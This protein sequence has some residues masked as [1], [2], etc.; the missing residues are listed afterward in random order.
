MTT[1]T[2]RYS[3]KGHAR[4]AMTILVDKLVE[5]S[6]VYEYI[7]FGDHRIGLKFTDKN[8]KERMIWPI[9]DMLV[10]VIRNSV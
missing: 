2:A 6:T 8:G 5:F 3:N 7:G 10:E 9:D 4:K 1:K